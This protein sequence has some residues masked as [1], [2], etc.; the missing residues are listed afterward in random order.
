[1]N[2]ESFCVKYFWCCVISEVKPHIGALVLVTARPPGPIQCLA[3]P[4]QSVWC[5][6]A[7]H[8]PLPAGTLTRMV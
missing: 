1:M 3:S 2:D 5:L 6:S 4:L 7:T 8:S